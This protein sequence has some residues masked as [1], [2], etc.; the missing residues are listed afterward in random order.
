MILTEKSKVTQ[1]KILAVATE[2][3]ARKGF[4]A[5][6]VRE[7]CTKAEANLAAVN[8]HFGG[9]MGLYKAV[10]S[11]AFENAK[12]PRPMPCLADDPAHPQDQLRAWIIWNAE[13]MLGVGGHAV[14][15]LIVK[16]LQDPTPAFDE[17]QARSM[18]PI[19]AAGE[20][21]IA[22]VLGVGQDD[23]RVQLCCTSVFGQCLIYRHARP[24]IERFQHYIQRAKQKKS[25]DKSADSTGEPGHL[26]KKID[27]LQSFLQYDPAIIAGIANHIADFSLAGIVAQAKRRRQKKQM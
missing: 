22:A 19:F 15:E 24:M 3:F 25:A 6:G 21:L 17:L 26:Q 2:I 23:P 13:R 7:I 4:Q 12:P 27:Q 18:Q 16:E 14:Y 5:T 8:Y 10:L 20:E 11:Y 1:D 9:K